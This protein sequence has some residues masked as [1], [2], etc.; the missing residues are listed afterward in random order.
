MAGAR[1]S[2]EDVCQD[3]R[4]RGQPMDKGTLST[5]LKKGI[6][7]FGTILN[8]GR[9]GRTTFLIWRKDYIPWAGEYIG[10]YIR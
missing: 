6:F 9:S 1:M 5:G 2:L 8:Q 10:E 3:M 7:P 4:R